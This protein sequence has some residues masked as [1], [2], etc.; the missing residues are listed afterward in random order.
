LGDLSGGQ[1][2]K[3]IAQRAM[4]LEGDG[5]AF[6]EFEQ[7]SDEKAFKTQYREAMNNLPIDDA[8]ADR[9]VDE[10]NH[11]FGLNMNMFKELEGS[12]IKAIG[13]MVFNALTRRRNRNNGELATAE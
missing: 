12:L 11:A 9:I 3:G 4:N 8:D 1:I 13:Q 5:T 2:L 10:A 7:I 6:Y